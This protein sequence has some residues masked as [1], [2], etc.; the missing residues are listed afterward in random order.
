M[1]LRW[2]ILIGIAY[3][4]FRLLRSMGRSRRIEVSRQGGQGE[5]IMVQDPCC[6]TFVPR[7]QALKEGEGDQALYFC[8]QQCRER[9]LEELAKGQGGAGRH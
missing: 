8:S 5:E 9:Y 6:K 4:I 1:W 3:L 7:S 2:A